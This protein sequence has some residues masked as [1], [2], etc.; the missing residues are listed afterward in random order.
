MN[1][2]KVQRKVQKV[3][4]KYHCHTISRGLISLPD[5]KHYKFREAS[6]GMFVHLIDNLLDE[7]QLKN[8]ATTCD[9]SMFFCGI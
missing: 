1:Y 8:N 7:M 3:W 4:S 9:A 5:T 6:Q 2:D